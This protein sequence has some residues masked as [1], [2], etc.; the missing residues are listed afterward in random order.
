MYRGL[1][2][3][4]F[5]GLTFFLGSILT[6]V[7]ISSLIENATLEKF[8]FGREIISKGTGLLTIPGLW[9]VAVS[10]IM[11]GYSRYGVKHRFFQLKLVL[12]ALILFNAHFLIMPSVFSAT[13]L[14]I[15]SFD[16]GQL[17]PEYETAYLNESIF[18]AVNVLLTLTAAVIAV[19]RVDDRELRPTH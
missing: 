6:F 15:Q 19:W 18:G 3:L 14:A 16:Q 17:L 9:V 2:L 1:K 10:G 12:A 7:V 8:A 5:T 4:H 13:D 11:M